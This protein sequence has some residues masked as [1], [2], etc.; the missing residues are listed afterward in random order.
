MK[1]IQYKNIEMIKDIWSF[2]KPY[3]SKLFIGS[4]LRA[5]SDIVWLFPPFALSEIITFLSSYQMG[6]SAAYIWNLMAL[7]AAT[8]I[9]HFICREWAK[10][11]I[12]QIAEQVDIDAR[13]K[14]IKHMFN[15]NLMWHEKE[16]SGN[17]MQKITKGG[18]SLSKIIRIYVDLIIEST[19]NLIAITI[20][21][22][23]LDW[24]LNI[25]LVFFFI[26][27]YVLSYF[28]TKKAVIQAHKANIEWEKFSGIT[29]ESINNISIV[30]SLRIGDKITPFINKASHKLIKEIKKRVS[31]FRIRG[32]ILG[33][34][35]ELFHLII[36]AF[37]IW[38][39]LIGHLEVGII[40]M[41]LFYFGKIRESAYE[42]SETYSRFATAKVAMLRMKEVL[43]EKP[44]I[45]QSGKLDFDTHWKKLKFKKVNFSY[46]GQNVI[47]DF[48]LTIHKGEKIGIVG[49]SGT[50]KSTLFK[51]I[52]KLYNNYEGGISFD[53][54][55]LKNIKRSSYMK[56]VTI[57]PQ[58]TELFN[59]SLRKNITLNQTNGESEL[60]QTALNISHVKDFAHKLPKGLSSLIGE[61]GIKLSGGEKQRVGIAR[62]VYRQPEILLLD[63]ATSHLDIDSE[64]Q[65]KDTLHK[66]FKNITAIVIA[67]RLSTIKEMDRIVLMH[68][69]RVSEVGTFDELMEKKGKFFGLWKK[70]QF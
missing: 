62:A 8:G 54:T 61:K 39:I 24:R 4:L 38:Q 18:E 17:K 9:Y 70:Q 47:K 52:L 65:I 64:R 55:S 12:Y 49:I 25:I 45:E 48:N 30:K 53:D 11:I 10:N 2:I 35:Q 19:I 22:F 67:H 44:T 57:V 23:T 68:N 43:L 56:K 46:H 13:K 31:Q 28:L 27:Y 41:V 58:K 69:G 33:L 66:F 51:L 5:T 40:A 16:N 20:I 34:Y 15:I 50:G 1:N 32:G 36:V 42:F 60:L 37:T 59:F 29:F 14:S 63:E 26:S 6:E 21:F 3:K 7:I